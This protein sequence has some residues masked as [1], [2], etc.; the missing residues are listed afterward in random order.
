MYYDFAHA[1]SF[2]TL[3]LNTIGAVIFFAYICWPFI[4]A[5]LIGWIIVQLYRS[6][7]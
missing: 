2:I 6:F 5:F 7:K 3:V 4:L 1:M